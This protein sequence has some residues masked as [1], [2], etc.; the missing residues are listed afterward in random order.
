MRDAHLLSGALR[1]LHQI[2]LQVRSDSDLVSAD[3]EPVKDQ[4]S[5]EAKSILLQMTFTMGE[6]TTPKLKI[7]N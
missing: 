7:Y 5:S 2:L 4:Y 6:T 3:S 1:L